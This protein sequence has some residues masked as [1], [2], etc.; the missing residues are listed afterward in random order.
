ML[1]S[2]IKCLGFDSILSQTIFS[3]SFVEFF[4]WLLTIPI[5]SNT[6]SMVLLISF[7]VMRIF[8]SIAAY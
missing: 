2:I 3:L 5:M 8:I 7:F 6:V 1:S 4:A